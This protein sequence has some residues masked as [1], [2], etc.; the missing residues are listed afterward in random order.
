MISGIASPE[1]C[2]RVKILGI[3]PKSPLMSRMYWVKSPGEV[4][5]KLGMYWELTGTRLNEEDPIAYRHSEIL[6]WFFNVTKAEFYLNKI[7]DGIFN[8]SIL[9][10]GTYYSTKPAEDWDSI[11]ENLVSELLD[12]YFKNS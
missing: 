1:S 5:R 3:S 2:E 10:K 6:Q 12:L 8:H 4:D 9:Y 7:S 11:H